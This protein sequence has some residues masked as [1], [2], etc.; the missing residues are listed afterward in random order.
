MATESEGVTKN[1]L[2]RIMLRSA[3]PSQAAPKS[4]IPPAG[5]AAITIKKHSL[6]EMGFQRGVHGQMEFQLGA[7]SCLPAVLSGGACRE[8]VQSANLDWICLVSQ[9]V[10]VK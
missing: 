1:L 10:S 4:G 7:H 5:S 2:P 3:S 6:L 9:F 8:R